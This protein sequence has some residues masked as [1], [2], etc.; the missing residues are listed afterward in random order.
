MTPEQIERRRE[1][2][3]ERAARYRAKVKDTPEFKAKVKLYKENRTEEQREQAR[4]SRREYA[5][6]R[7]AKDPEKANAYKR[8]LERK[9]YKE[10]PEKHRAEILAWKKANVARVA[11]NKV[12]W[13]KTDKCWLSICKDN[14]AKQL[15]VLRKDVPDELA[16]AKFAQLKVRRFVRDLG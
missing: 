1:Y 7:R 6:R 4:K 10:S 8:A 16:E 15:G 9:R 11:A 14:L 2:S 3:R 12:K 5:A 13:R